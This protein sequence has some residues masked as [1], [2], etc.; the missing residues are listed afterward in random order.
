M[1]VQKKICPVCL[2]EFDAKRLNQIYCNANN[3]YCRNYYNNEKARKLKKAQ[4]EA[5]KKLAMSWRHLNE[6]L[7]NEKEVT[8][9]IE[10]LKGRGIDLS[11]FSQYT[12]QN[13][14]GIY[15]IFNIKI[16]NLDNINFKIFR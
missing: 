14:K 5:P 7:G 6:I 16:V 1:R 9:H 8:R 12:K 3:H 11:Y 4:G 10:Y 15:H 13:D 2:K